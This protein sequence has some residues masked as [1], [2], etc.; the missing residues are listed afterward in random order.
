MTHN[1]YQETLGKYLLGVLITGHRMLDRTN[2][3]ETDFLNLHSE[4]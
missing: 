2:R 4:N 3:L 1:V